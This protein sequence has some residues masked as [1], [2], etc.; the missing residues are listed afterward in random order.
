MPVAT[1]LE[2]DNR[3]DTA[4]PWLICCLTGLLLTCRW[5]L[6][7]ESATLGDTLWLAQ[8]TLLLPLIWAIR[9]RKPGTKSVVW[10]TPDVCVW[11][12]VI[13]HWMSFV[14]LVTN[15]GQLRAA[16]NLCWEWTAIGCMVFALR[17]CLQSS[18]VR[19]ACGM[20]PM[21]ESAKDSG[22]EDT[23]T[24]ILSE[25]P[26]PREKFI[27]RPCRTG[28]TRSAGRSNSI[29]HEFRIS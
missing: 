6:P 12:I 23:M 8:C 9:S 19:S 24:R 29:Q 4:E 10:G 3:Q 16:L 25:K 28:V 15:G 1:N 21:K 17:Q 2:M 20:L 7:V 14:W 11:S 22:S 27:G 13:G 5:M 26:R 18:V